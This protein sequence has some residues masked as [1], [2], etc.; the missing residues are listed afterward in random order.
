MSFEYKLTNIKGLFL[1]EEHFS[2]GRPSQMIKT[3]PAAKV[4]ILTFELRSDCIGD[5]RLS[6]EGEVFFLNSLSSK[7]SSSQWYDEY[8]IIKTMGIQPVQN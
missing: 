6:K 1:G 8:V 7:S 5:L 3:E 2:S 4:T